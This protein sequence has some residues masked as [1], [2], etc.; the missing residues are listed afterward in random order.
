MPNSLK[1]LQQALHPYLQPVLRLVLGVVFLQSGYE[2]LHHLEEFYQAAQNYQVLPPGVT[3]F[4]SVMVPWLEMLAGLYLLLGLFT[5]FAAL[6]TA[7]LLV[8]FIIA[9]AM[10]LIRGDAVDCGCFV[11]G[12]ESPV[13]VWLLVRDVAMLLGAVYL[14]WTKPIPQCLDGFLNPPEAAEPE[15][16]MAG[17][18][19]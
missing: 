9:I 8:S 7:G 2:K 1:K 13:D 4:Y 12:E 6:L 3:H 15:P 10:V 11:G 16:V 17:K 5:R 19:S 18:S 14:A